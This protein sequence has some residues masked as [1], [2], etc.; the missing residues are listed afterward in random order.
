MNERNLRA[1]VGARVAERVAHDPAPHPLRQPLLEPVVDAF[2]HVDAARGD[3]GLSLV[4]E[5]GADGELHGHVEVGV[6][7]DDERGLAA[8]LQVD[9]LQVALRGGLHY[10]APDLRGSGETH[11]KQT[12][13]VQGNARRASDTRTRRTNT[14]EGESPVV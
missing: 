14:Y 10:E 11:L 13:M 1:L 6:V 8:Q 4:E 12:C 7:E 9:G 3:A 2:L 5:A